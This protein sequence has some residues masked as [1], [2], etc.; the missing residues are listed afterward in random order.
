VLPADLVDRLLDFHSPDAPV[1]SLYAEIPVDPGELRGL[2]S[3]VHSLLKPVRAL[4]DSDALGHYDRESLRADMAQVIEFAQQPRG[5]VGRAVTVIACHR[6]GLYEAFT[7][8]RRVRDQ[9]VVD[10]TPYLRPLLAL[11]DELRRYCVVVVERTRSQLF[12]FFADELE[13]V[14]EADPGVA[15]RRNGPVHSGDER[16]AHH[17]AEQLTRHHYRQTAERIEEMRQRTGADLVVVGG[18]A[19]TIAEFLPYLPPRLG[20][21]VAGTFIV[22]PHTATPANV[23]DEAAAVVDAYERDEEVRGVE[24]A[25]ARAASRGLGAAGLARCLVAVNERAVEL[26]LVHHDAQQPGRVSDNCGWLG[27][28]GDDCPVCGHPLRETPDVIDDMAAAVVDAG[29][30]VEHVHADTALADARVAAWLR[31]PLQ[32]P[33]QAAVG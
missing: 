26:L 32:E 12:E 18:H 8:P 31:F 30:R 27:L 20:T 23:R 25:L 14:E 7:L 22:D 33:E 5:L 19:E 10:A 24:E 21:Q 28:S 13:V 15:K 9:A 1:L 2:E 17:R 29:G 3:R 16:H 11:L 6:A 4:A